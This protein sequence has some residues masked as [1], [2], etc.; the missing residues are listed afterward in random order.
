MEDGGE[1][2]SFFC[3]DLKSTNGTFVNELNLKDVTGRRVAMKHDA[4]QA[5]SMNQNGA[6][7]GFEMCFAASTKSTFGAGGEKRL[8]SSIKKFKPHISFMIDFFQDVIRFGNT[9]PSFKFHDCS[10]VDKEPSTYITQNKLGEGAYGVVYKGMHRKTGQ[11][12]AIKE[13]S[14]K[15]LKQTGRTI[16]A[17][18]FKEA[19][20]LQGLDHPNV[21]RV[22]D[23]IDRADDVQIVMWYAVGGDLFDRVKSYPGG[24]MTETIARNIFKQLL[25][26]VAYLHSKGCSHRDLKL[27]NIL[28]DSQEAECNVKIA[29]FGLAKIVG[30]GASVMQTKCGTAEYQAPEIIHPQ[31][32]GAKP[33]Y[34]NA[35]DLWSLGVILYCGSVPAWRTP[36]TRYCT[37]DDAPA[38]SAGDTVTCPQH[39]ILCLRQRAMGARRFCSARPV[40]VAGSCVG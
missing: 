36:A 10:T 14:K 24:K 28:L 25:E 4:S 22:Y 20:I 19:K 5:Y 40:Y 9:T 26:G 15:R 27:E 31:G 30:P 29:D 8:E 34:S 1:C 18:Q 6:T 12:V 2:D 23:I 21:V 3:E 11:V 17:D 35:I 37:P 13:I 32:G 7:S 38:S 16:S 33:G 39:Y